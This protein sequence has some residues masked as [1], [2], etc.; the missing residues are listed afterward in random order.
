LNEIFAATM[1]PKTGLALTVANGQ[2]LRVTDIEGKQVVDMAI[3]NLDD[4]PEKLSTAN[5]RTRYIPAPGERYAPRDHIQEG[6]FVMSTLCRPMMKIV[7]ETAEPKGVHD[8]NNR[9]CNR[10]LFEVFGVGPRDGCQEIITRAIEPYG[11]GAADIPDTLDLFMNYP[12]NCSKGHFEILEPVS[13]PGDYIE[14]QALMDCLVALSNCPEDVLTDCNARNCTP[15]QVQV[16]EGPADSPA[17]L[18]PGDWLDQ[19][20]RAR[21]MR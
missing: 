4:L 9:M 18:P 21:G 11:L 5:S 19:E 10:F 8:S 14:F 12:H 13:K 1:P 6:D 17:P 20:L 7:K 16:F 15:M 2:Y 3:F